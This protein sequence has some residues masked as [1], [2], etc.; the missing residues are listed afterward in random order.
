M[1]GQRRRDEANRWL[2]QLRLGQDVVVEGRRAETSRQQEDGVVGVLGAGLV[3]CPAE[4]FMRACA[5]LLPSNDA[6]IL[7]HTG[8]ERNSGP[9]A[10]MHSACAL[11]SSVGAPGIEASRVLIDKAQLGTTF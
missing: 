1:A 8:I 10:L 4:E 7:S 6:P 9:L 2:S 3:Q 5:Q 11:P